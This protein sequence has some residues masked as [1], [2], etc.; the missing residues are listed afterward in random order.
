MNN[1]TYSEPEQVH[2]IFIYIYNLAAVPTGI[3]TLMCKI[4]TIIILHEFTEFSHYKCNDMSV[5]CY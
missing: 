1:H 4:Y 2:C 3:A 5:Y